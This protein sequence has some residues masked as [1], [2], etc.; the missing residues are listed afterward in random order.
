MRTSLSICLLLCMASFATAHEGHSHAPSPEAKERIVQLNTQAPK[1]QL[2]AFQNAPEAQAPELAKLFEPFKKTVKVRFDKDYLFVESNGMPAHPMMVGITAWQQQ[3]PLPQSYFG[4]NAWRIPLHP[5]PAKNPLSTKEHFFRGAIALAVNG[6]PIFNPIKNDGT[7]DTLANGELDQWGGHCG[8]ADDYHYHIAPVHL[9]KLVGAGNPVAVALDGYPIYGYNDPNGKPPTDLDWLNGH[10]GPDGK[11][12]YH[13]TKTFPYLNGGFYGE[14]VERNGQVDPQPRARPLRPSLSGLKGAKITGF[15]NPKPDSYAVVYEVNGDKRSV[16]YTVSDDGSVTFNFVSQRGTTTETYKHREQSEDRDADRRNGAPSPEEKRPAQNAQPDSNR[17]GGGRG[18]PQSQGD[19]RRGGGQGQQ[20]G[21]QP[22]GGGGQRQGGGGDPIVQALDANRDG[23]LDKDEIQKAPSALLSLDK[24]RDGQ[25][26]PEELRRPGG[27][28]DQEP[29][30]QGRQGGGGPG[31]RP[32]P[33]DP[34]GNDRPNQAG[35]PQG[36]PPGDG[37]RQPW[38]LVH[39]EEIDLNE[40]GIISRDEIVGEAEKAFGGYD[41]DKDGV[42]SERELNAKENVRSAMG[43]FFR[44]HAKE[45]DRDNDGSLTRNEAVDNATKMFEKIDSNADGK[46]TQEELEASMRV[47]DEPQAPDRNPKRERGTESPT[48]SIPRSRV[49]LPSRTAFSDEPTRPNFIFIL[50]DDMG[51]KDM[52]FSGNEFIETP[53]T[54]RLAREGIIFSQA[55]ASAPNCAPSR[56]CIMSGQYPPRHGIYTVVDERH[57]P[58]S[59]HHK[60]LA[61]HSND[62]MDTEVVTIA[63]CLKDAGYATAAFGMWN[64]GRG[65]SGPSTA[66]GQGFDF[67]KKPQD[68]GFER[69]DYFDK[70]GNFITDVFTNMGIEFIESNQNRPFFL[71]LPYHA[72]HAPFQP[73]ADLVAKYE[74]KA[75]NTTVADAD[76]VYAAMVDA[77]DQNVGR[78]METLKRLELDDNTMVIFTSDNGGI[79]QFVAPLNGSKGALYEG[80][81]RVPACVW[82]SGIKDAGRTCDTPIL[83]MD[84]Y[85]TMLEAAGINRPNLKLDGVSFIPVLQDT[86]DVE[87][88]AVFWHFP[89]YVG[90]GAPSSAIRMGDW[91][92]IEKYEDRSLELYNLA[93]D[94]GESRNLASTNAV[95]ANELYARLTSWQKETTA[96]IPSP[97]NPNY[98]PSAVRERS[99]GGQKGGGQ[100]RGQNR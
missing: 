89:S 21:G 50:I 26:T 70:S 81:I 46:I 17:V 1:Q 38:I 85:P 34:R 88:D 11:Y 35:R 57:A 42:L 80:G 67:Y 74:S 32:Q 48:A 23:V 51:W 79:P 53:N 4:D 92:L 39:A 15:E 31:G 97:S 90:R 76:P 7:T 59:A 40:D 55:Y 56:A 9:E 37:P 86:G 61:A 96:A 91:K 75:K 47:S 49:G 20:G 60:I 52:G 29:R 5:V 95:K 87:R 43:G 14:V 73:K 71:Y 94:V 13:A 99:K 2:V 44:G 83:G 24:N 62:T 28:P 98:D 41:I 25:L 78:I 54:D 72:I 36:P 30:V 58:G 63:E 27:Q 33:G 16:E 68:C 69:H 65:N 6:V 22:R 19:Q 93:E 82:W 100:N 45:L 84:F 10:K 66:T 8:R 64:L 3:V 77:V 18:G 12:H